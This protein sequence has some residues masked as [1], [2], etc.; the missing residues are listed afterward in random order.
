[1]PSKMSRSVSICCSLNILRSKRYA[2]G[3]TIEAIARFLSQSTDVSS[4]RSIYK[5]G[6]AATVV[7]H[8][9]SDGNG[10]GMLVART[11]T[12]VIIPENG[13]IVSGTSELVKCIKGAGEAFWKTDKLISLSS[14]LPS[15]I[16]KYDGLIFSDISL[17]T[18]AVP[19]PKVK[20]E[21]LDVPAIPGVPEVPVP[22]FPV[23][24]LPDVA[25]PIVPELP[26]PE[27][28][29]E[30]P[31]PK[32]KPKPGKPKIPLPGKPEPIVPDFP[33][34]GLPVPIVPDP[35]EPVLPTLPPEKPLDEP[36][37]NLDPSKIACVY[38]N[39]GN[40]VTLVVKKV[41][42]LKNEIHIFLNAQLFDCQSGHNYDVLFCTQVEDEETVWEN[43]KHGHSNKTL[44]PLQLLC[45]N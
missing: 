42:F 7:I 28:P 34:P 31:M 4:F 32:P 39:L 38:Q 16:T 6:N 45:T 8:E 26:S 21:P 40:V 27:I 25:V 17:M 18:P 5:N 2:K 35:W 10:S 33:M 13:I 29:P 36:S 44:R 1:M 19:K 23:P 43:S 20:P 14:D 41:M 9:E 11:S 3:P 22:E 30:F 37:S 24:G 15:D 12:S